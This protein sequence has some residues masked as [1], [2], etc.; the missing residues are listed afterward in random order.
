M[1]IPGDVAA[2]EAAC[3]DPYTVV[4]WDVTEDRHDKIF[5]RWLCQD[6]NSHYSTSI[7]PVV[8]SALCAST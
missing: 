8:Y 5:T 3:S 1:A 7:F 2:R 4:D 6:P